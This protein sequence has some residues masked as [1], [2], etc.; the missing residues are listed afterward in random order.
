MPKPVR[1][2]EHR[3]GDGSVVG[4]VDENTGS[5]GICFGS[6]YGQDDA[7]QENHEHR[8]P[9]EHQLGAVQ[10]GETERGHE[11]GDEQTEAAREHGIKKAAKKKLFHQ[12]REGNAQDTERPGFGRS[13]KKAVDWQLFGNRQK[14][15]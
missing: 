8:S 6:D 7:D 3:Y 2:G 10:Q 9:G 1:G 12:R 4:H 14:M 13:A 11:D 5:Y 15:S